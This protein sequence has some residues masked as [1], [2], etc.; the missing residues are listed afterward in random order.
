MSRSA[1]APLI[2]SEPLHEVNLHFICDTAKVAIVPLLVLE[3]KRNQRKM[4]S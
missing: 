4:Q 1:T 3:K 2:N